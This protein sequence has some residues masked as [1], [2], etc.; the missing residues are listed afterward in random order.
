[1]ESLFDGEEKNRNDAVFQVLMYAMVY[2]KLNP[3][4]AVLPALCFVRGSHTENF[5]YHIQY[6]EKKK[7]LE[8]YQEI[9]NEFEGMLKLKLA[10]LFDTGE[11]EL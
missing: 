5:S 6:G 3:G 4:S 1:V 10:S 9:E 2:H 7:A 8:S 11:G